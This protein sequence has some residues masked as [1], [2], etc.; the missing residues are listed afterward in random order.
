MY[1]T[2]RK[3]LFSIAYIKAIGSQLGYN[4]GE[5]KIDNDSVDILFS[6]KG[7][8]GT[9]LRNPQ[10]NFQLK[11]TQS[12]FSKN[13]ILH[14]S[15]PKNNYD[16]LRADNNA[17]P[18]YLIVLVVPGDDTQW[19]DYRTAEIALKYR[20]YW[21]SLKNYPPSNN[22]NKVKVKIPINNLFNDK[23]FKNLMDAASNGITL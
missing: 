8:K 14:F 6:T 10:L 3:E 16:D 9:K 22:K 1:I 4:P 13:G 15:L 20:S 2:H 11:C 19:I 17:N 5:F 18:S 21:L 12:S 23:V 7:Y